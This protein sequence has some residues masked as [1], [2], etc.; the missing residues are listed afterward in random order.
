MSIMWSYKIKAIFTIYS[1]L[2]KLQV[3]W[4]TALE[5][6]TLPIVKYIVK[7]G[8]MGIKKVMKCDTMYISEYIFEGTSSLNLNL[9]GNK[10]LWGIGQVNTI[11]WIDVLHSMPI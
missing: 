6:H 2:I 7:N 3:I 11:R 4:D 8:W 1:Q 5:S 9:P 10:W